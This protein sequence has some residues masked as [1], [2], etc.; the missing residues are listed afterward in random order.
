MASDGPAEEAVLVKDP[1]CASLGLN[2]ARLAGLDRR[3]PGLFEV[4]QMAA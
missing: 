4:A 2:D 3:A 1:I